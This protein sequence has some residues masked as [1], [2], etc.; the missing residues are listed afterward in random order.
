MAFG[1]G[2]FWTVVTLVSTAGVKTLKEYQLTATNFVNAELA[3]RV[4]IVPRLT[5][6][7]KLKVVSYMVQ[8]IVLEESLTLPTAGM[9]ED[10]LLVTA[11]VAGN[12]R[13][14]AALRIP[15]PVDGFFWRPNGSGF[16][17]PNFGNSALANYLAMFYV[18]GNCLTSDGEQITNVNLKGRRIHRTTIRK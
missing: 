17:E 6:V 18:G 16:N 8:W 5:A 9:P 7:T 11:Q 10:Q 2:K 1:T 15:A 13:K 12:A 4:T 3:A 14:H